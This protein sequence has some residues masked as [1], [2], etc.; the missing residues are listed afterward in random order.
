MHVTVCFVGRNVV[1]LLTILMMYTYFYDN[2]SNSRAFIGQFLLSI[3]GQT[4]EFEIH[5]TRQRARA[6]N[7]TICYRKKRIDVSF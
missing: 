5:A 7:L 3:C 4:H 6:G 1:L 2:C